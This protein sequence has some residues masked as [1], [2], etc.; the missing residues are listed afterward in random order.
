MEIVIIKNKIVKNTGEMMSNDFVNNNI[1]RKK[2]A[3]SKDVL[4]V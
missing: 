3:G 1:E 4:T 2:Q